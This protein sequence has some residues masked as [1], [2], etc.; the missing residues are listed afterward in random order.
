MPWARLGLSSGGLAAAAAAAALPQQ[1][2]LGGLVET[3]DARPATEES[4][5]IVAEVKP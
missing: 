1:L 4:R 2:G 3:E 5:M